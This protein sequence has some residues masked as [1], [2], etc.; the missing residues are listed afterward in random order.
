MY[1]LIYFMI[2]LP[3][4]FLALFLLSR[5]RRK[6]TNELEKVL[7]LQNDPQL[8]LKLLANP[9]LKILY[10]KSTLLQFELNA[11]LLSGD[12]LQIERVT[13]LLDAMAMTKGESLEYQQKKLSYYCSKGDKAKAE[14]ALNRIESILSKAKGDQ[15]RF[16]LKESR[17]IFGVYI[18]H[19]T[20]LIK[21][22]E[23]AQMKEKGA[24][25]GITLYRLA[26]LCYFDGDYKKAQAYLLEAKEMLHNTAWFDI[27][28][29]ALI[30]MS[31]F[32]RF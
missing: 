32:D 20:K 18:E 22:L 2:L 7:Y 23:K 8:F 31:V 27:V 28:E 3:A 25:R 5:L 17:I 29:L 16:I 4:I 15:A 30:D 12:D 10:R 26:K 13:G 6:T 1:R 21:E 14:A 9:K 24:V 11:Y 19:D